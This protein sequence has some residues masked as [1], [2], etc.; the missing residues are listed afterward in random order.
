VTPAR[1]SPACG[2]SSPRRQDYGLLLGVLAETPCLRTFN[3]P[4]RRGRLGA[5]RV[6]GRACAQSLM[7]QAF[8]YP[9]PFSRRS[10]FQSSRSGRSRWNPQ[11]SR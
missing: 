4:F 10:S 6:K 11:S 3:H 9:S 8:L 7:R 1:R 2:R 5:C